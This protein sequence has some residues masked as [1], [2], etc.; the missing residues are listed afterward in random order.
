M[1]TKI[2]LSPI[3]RNTVMKLLDLLDA[4][5]STCHFAPA[6]RE[7]YR[8]WV[9]NYLRYHQQLQGK[10]IHPQE[11]REPAVQSFLTHLAQDRQL[12]ASSQ[13]QT[14]C[15]LVLLYRAVLHG[16]HRLPVLRLTMPRNFQMPP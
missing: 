12:A 1:S 14:M 7:C 11:L 4:R 3:Y 8:R 2:G 16:C 5:C 10:W 15:A 13:S 6:T 9:V